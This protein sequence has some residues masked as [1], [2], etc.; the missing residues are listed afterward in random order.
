MFP[1]TIS[2]RVSLPFTDGQTEVQRAQPL[3]LGHRDQSPAL[4]PSPLWVSLG[5]PS[6]G[7]VLYMEGDL[8]QLAALLCRWRQQ[9]QQVRPLAFRDRGGHRACWKQGMVYPLPC[10]HPEKKKKSLWPWAR[11]R[12]AGCVS[13][14]SSPWNI[15]ASPTPRPGF[16]S[17]IWPLRLSILPW[18]TLNSQGNHCPKGPHTLPRTSGASVPMV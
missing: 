12:A 1:S 11:R 8:V 18:V 4:K 16:F 13:V 5:L 10:P 7:V 14:A 9:H 2:I 15:R 17:S 3:V 6:Q